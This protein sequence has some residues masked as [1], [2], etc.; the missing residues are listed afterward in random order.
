MSI[1]KSPAAYRRLKSIRG[2]TRTPLSDAAMTAIP[3]Y[4]KQTVLTHRRSDARMRK[5]IT[6]A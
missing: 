2:A 5:W 4:G 6:Y 3:R 1:S